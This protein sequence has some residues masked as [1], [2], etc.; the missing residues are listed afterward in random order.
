MK[1]L[2]ITLTS[3]VALVANV[4]WGAI[5]D[6][7]Q[8]ESEA[9]T[10]FYE[11]K[12]GTLVAYQAA[13]NSWPELRNAVPAF[14]SIHRRVDVTAKTHPE[15]CFW[16]QEF[17]AGACLYEQEGSTWLVSQAEHEGNVVGI[18]LSITL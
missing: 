3:A 8:N 6:S 9:I 10:A 4:G 2:M 15:A 11:E 14:V 17:N 5:S 13:I 1:S 12:A 7:H 18:R 16:V